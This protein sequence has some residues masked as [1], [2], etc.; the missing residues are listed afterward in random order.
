VTIAIVDDGIDQDHPDLQPNFKQAGSYNYNTNSN[1]TRPVNLS[2]HGDW[3]GTTSAGVAAARDDGE[4][5]GVGVAPRAGLSAVVILQ[6]GSVSDAVEA[7]AIT[8]ALEVNDIY[9]NSWGPVD[10]GRRKEAPGPLTQRAFEHALENGRRGLGTIYV[11]AAGNGRRSSDECNYD[12]YANWRGTVLIGAIS[13][14]GSSVWYSESCAALLGVTP[15][16]GDSARKDPDIV[17][18]DLMKGGLETGQCTS[19][20]TGTSASC[21]MAAGIIALMLEANPELSWLDVQYILVNSCVRTDVDDS[22]WKQNGAGRWVNHKFG[23]GLIDTARAVQLSLAHKKSIKEESR[24]FYSLEMKSWD[25]ESPT[26][27]ATI[28]V[29][30][31][32]LELHHVEIRV[33]ITHRIRGKL[34]IVLTAPSGLTSTLA[35][36]HNDG[37]ADYSS[38]RFT[39]LRHWGEDVTGNWTLVIQDTGKL[40]GELKDWSLTFFGIPHTARVPQE[41]PTAVITDDRGLLL[42]NYL[43]TMSVFLT[44][45]MAG[46]LFVYYRKRK[47]RADP[48]GVVNIL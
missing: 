39:S 48:S 8:H 22:D 21:P 4:V 41:D 19:K 43:T 44:L 15:S 31:D 12:G 11:W 2:A 32:S 40:S 20:F 34:N 27:S 3:H 5:C 38:W 17:T 37:G 28:M 6:S 46:L 24:R 45:V 36:Q 13:W 29:P 1:N 23:F 7:R 9:S 25:A 30:S 33:N 14:K 42:R 16:S 47:A 35:S 18:T 10:D 26:T